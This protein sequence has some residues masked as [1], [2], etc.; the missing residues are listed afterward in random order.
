MWFVF[1][2]AHVCVCVCVCKAYFSNLQVR[3]NPHVHIKH[4]PELFPCRF[5][6]VQSM[7]EVKPYN[8]CGGGGREEEEGEGEV[9]G[10][11]KVHVVKPSLG[12]KLRRWRH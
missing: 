12:H 1:F 10:G 2:F 6:K 9:E 3:V 11:N 4:Q 7:C 8:Y 5:N